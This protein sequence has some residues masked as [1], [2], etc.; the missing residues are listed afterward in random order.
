MS[1]KAQIKASRK[2]ND[3]N[4]KGYYLRFNR[5]T[6]ADIISKLSQVQN[7]TSY[8]RGLILADIFQKHV[9]I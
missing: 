8:I 3:N 6:D 9:D 1:S 4:T 2:Y 5:K 7:K